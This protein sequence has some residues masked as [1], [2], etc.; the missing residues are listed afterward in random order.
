MYP[1]IRGPRDLRHKSTDGKRP[2]NFD[3]AFGRGVP[4]D[5]QESQQLSGDDQDGDGPGDVE[6]G[7]L[8]RLV[9]PA[10]H[11]PSLHI[12]TRGIHLAL[13]VAAMTM[14]LDSV[15]RPM[16]TEKMSRYT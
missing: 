8:E 6:E 1:S 15:Q 12:R 4:D 3:A 2:S 13:K 5:P 16:T 11:E 14:M 7:G 10:E 9:R